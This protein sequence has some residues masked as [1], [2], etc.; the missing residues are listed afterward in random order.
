MP[1]PAGMGMAALQV[2]AAIG[3]RQPGHMRPASVEYTRPPEETLDFMDRDLRQG[4]LGH[5]G[6]NPEAPGDLVL[7]GGW[8]DCV[9]GSALLVSLC[10]ARGIPSRLVSGYGLYAAASGAHNWLEVWFEG[11]GWMPFDLTSLE[12]G[13]GG[14]ARDWRDCFLGC[15][16]HR[17][18]VE[19]L[20]RLFAGMGSLN[21]PAAWHLLAAANSEGVVHDL[22]DAMT[23][24]RI[25]SESVRVEALGL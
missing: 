24:D 16:D 15:L 1:S 17:M 23:G 6:L 3:W 7:D 12:L 13:Q 11:R 10:R 19:R 14:V 4:A 8:Y 5:H 9:A 18:V 22:V 2:Q 25:Y 20:P 21:L